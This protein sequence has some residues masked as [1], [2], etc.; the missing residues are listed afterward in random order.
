MQNEMVSVVLTDT[1]IKVTLGVEVE[2][3]ESIRLRQ[4]DHPLTV[5]EISHRI[6]IILRI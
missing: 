4:S 5:F 3:I 2:A 6:S 1:L